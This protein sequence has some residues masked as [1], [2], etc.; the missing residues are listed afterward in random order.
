MKVLLTIVFQDP[1]KD[2]PKKS[3]FLKNGLNGWSFAVLL[4]KSDRETDELNDRPTD[5]QTGGRTDKTH[6][7]K[8]NFESSKQR[9]VRTSVKSKHR[10]KEP[11]NEAKN[12]KGQETKKQ[13]TK[14]TSKHL[15][16][17]TSDK[18]RQKPT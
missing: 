5:R 2:N 8:P 18:S 14:E 13:R 9:L 6:Y 15:N 3:K 12:Q 11:Q 17:E 10:N 7:Q 4:Q 16:I 1:K